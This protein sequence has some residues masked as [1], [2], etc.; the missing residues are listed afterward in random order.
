MQTTIRYRIR[1]DGRVE[2]LVEGVRGNAC[3]VLTER[4]EARIGTVSNRVP[5]AEAY[6]PSE[7]RHSRSLSLGQLSS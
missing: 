4:I 3:E 5:T 7:L 6:L 2:Q 1:P